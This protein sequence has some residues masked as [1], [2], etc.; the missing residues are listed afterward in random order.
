MAWFSSPA[1]ELLGGPDQKPGCPLGPHSWVGVRMQGP[2]Q[3]F[4]KGA[5]GL[6][7]LFDLGTRLT[8]EARAPC[9]DLPLSWRGLAFPPPA[10]PPSSFTSCHVPE[11]V[12]VTW[13]WH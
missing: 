12:V 3:S 6:R 1:G 4:V 11:T 5:G 13:H 7:I 9:R 2:F 8:L 10:F